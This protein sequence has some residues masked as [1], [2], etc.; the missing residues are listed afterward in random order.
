MNGSE[1]RQNG[2]QID[3]ISDVAPS[4]LGAVVDDA[5]DPFADQRPAAGGVGT[6]QLPNLVAE[7]DV[8]VERAVGIRRRVECG[9]RVGGPNG[10][11]APGRLERARDLHEAV[12]ERRVHDEHGM[13]VG[14]RRTGGWRRRQTRSVGRGACPGEWTGYPLPLI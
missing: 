9:C 3:V 13:D 2:E 4:Q 12:S 8:G 11:P 6:H 7:A 14:A 10:Y 5:A 1:R